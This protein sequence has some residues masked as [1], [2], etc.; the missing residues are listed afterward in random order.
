MLP[1]LETAVSNKYISIY[2]IDM[3]PN[4]LPA[5]TIVFYIELSL[6]LSYQS[7]INVSV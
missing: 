4:N 6:S 5:A 2:T 3:F 1:S 7:I